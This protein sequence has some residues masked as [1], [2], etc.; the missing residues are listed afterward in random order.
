L[1]AVHALISATLKAGS[2]V[3]IHEGFDGM[4]GNPVVGPFIDQTE[5]AHVL[6][7]SFQVGD[8]QVKFT[9][10]RMR[11]G[12]AKVSGYSVPN[13]ATPAKV[14]QEAAALLESGHVLTGTTVYSEEL[15]EGVVDGHL[16]SKELLL[17]VVGLDEEVTLPDIHELFP[18]VQEVFRGGGGIRI[19][20]R[21]KAQRDIILKT[22]YSVEGHKVSL[23]PFKVNNNVKA[24]VSPL[25]ECIKRI[26]DDP[27]NIDPSETVS[28]L[29]R[30]M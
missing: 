28:G 12:N 23:R 20:C 25:A 2:H 27:V 17:K 4:K 16:V 8:D 26:L 14:Q 19:L 18:E 30:P 15:S 1:D 29:W 11:G 5:R 7:Q 21:D 10:V 3:S 13:F 22:E 9:T 6:A 24:L